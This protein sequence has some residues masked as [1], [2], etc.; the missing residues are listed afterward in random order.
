MMDL[1]MTLTRLMRPYTCKSV[2]YLFRPS[3]PLKI[4]ILLASSTFWL[5]TLS[6]L[7]FPPYHKPP[8]GVTLSIVQSN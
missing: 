3:H 6:P 8:V 1:P 7:F 4:Y 2:L 5:I